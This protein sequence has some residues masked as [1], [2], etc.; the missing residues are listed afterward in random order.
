MRKINFVSTKINVENMSV[1]SAGKEYEIRFE[2]STP[3]NVTESKVFKAAVQAADMADAYSAVEKS[4][5]LRASFGEAAI[6]H[7]DSAGLLI[8]TDKNNKDTLFAVKHNMNGATKL[9]NM[10]QEVAMEEYIIRDN[11][12]LLKDVWG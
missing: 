1:E 7:D 6:I 2:Y 11:R 9:L 3:D 5:R 4:F 10:I 12:N 8:F